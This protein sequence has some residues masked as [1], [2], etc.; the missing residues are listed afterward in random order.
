MYAELARQQD[1]EVL[2]LGW[3]DA[4]ERQRV[5]A[6][7]FREGRQTMKLRTMPNAELV[8]LRRSNGE[9][10]GWTGVDVKTDPTFS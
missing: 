1:P 6:L 4:Q 7:A 9:F 8:V 10:A 3:A 2:I 5:I